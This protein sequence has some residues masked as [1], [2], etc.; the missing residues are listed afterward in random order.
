MNVMVT[1]ASGFIG[2]HVVEAM[3]T[4][5]AV[6]NIFALYR[7]KEQIAFLPKVNPVIG[8]LD[9]LPSIK[10]D[11]RID[12]I[13]HLAGY[14]KTETKKLCE[15]INVDG[16]KN[17]VS[18]CR[19]NNI[20]RIIF[21]STINVNLKTKG[22]YAASKEKAEEI[23]RNSGIEYMIVRPSLVYA[24]RAGSLGRIIGYAEKF[25]ILPIFGSGKAKEQPIH[26][27][28]LVDLTLMMIKDFKPGAEIYAAGRDA[29]PFSALV[30]TI[31]T[32][33]GK[34]VR[35]MPIPAKPVYWLVKLAEKAGI[36]PGLS[37]EQIAHMSQDLTADM[38]ETLKLYPIELKPFEEN[39]KSDL[40][41][42]R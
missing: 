42:K 24:G 8:D 29:M 32:C 15:K 39:I 11:A 5:P 17:T 26:I 14:Y 13:V 38:T 25:P 23:V 3:S 4:E 27:N 12:I 37:S 28:E 22:C 30:R 19:E 35:I 41:G 7:N 16:T 34:K 31:G 2:K 9:S 20:P 40:K 6:D 1:G 10:V 18:F 33:I 21:F 36:H